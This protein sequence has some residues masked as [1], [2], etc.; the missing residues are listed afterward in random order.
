MRTFSRLTKVERRLVALRIAHANDLDIGRVLHIVHS[1]WR[2]EYELA[3]NRPS[4]RLDDHLHTA[5]AVD[6]IHEHVTVSV[7]I[8]IPEE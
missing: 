3:P 2:D 8:G 6:A 7:S 1:L 4:R 5:F